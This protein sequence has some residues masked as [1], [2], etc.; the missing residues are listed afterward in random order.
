MEFI[1]G[2]QNALG[3]EG[4]EAVVLRSRYRARRGTGRSGR[5]V[6]NI[7]VTVNNKP[8]HLHTRAWI[9]RKNR[10]VSGTLSSANNGD[11]P[12]VWRRIQVL[13]SGLT[14]PKNHVDTIKVPRI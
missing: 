10:R 9:L 3:E 6:S 7:R 13:E 8:G 2:K 4:E 5:G 12:A 11:H 14:L 1:K